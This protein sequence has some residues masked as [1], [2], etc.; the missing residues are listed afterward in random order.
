M[1]REGQSEPFEQE[2]RMKGAEAVVIWEKRVP[3]EGESKSRGWSWCKI[4]FLS[5]NN[6]IHSAAY[7]CL[8]M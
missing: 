6:K 4:V 5:K 8:L 2:T 3:G 7:H 1:G